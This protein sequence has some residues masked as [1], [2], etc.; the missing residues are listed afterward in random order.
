MDK[1]I[2]DHFKKFD[3]IL[4][5]AFQ[6]IKIL[7]EFEVRT[8]NDYFRSLCGEIIGQQLSGKAADTI[9]GRFEKLFSRKKITPEK[10]LKIPDEKLRGAGMAWS[11]V[12][13]IK[14]LAKK[15]T[16]GTLNL[17][18]LKD[19]EDH[20]VVEEITQVKGIGPWTAE[21]F[22]MFTLQRED[23]FSHGDLGLRK[24]IKKLYKFKKE[25]SK[26]QIEKIAQKW[27]PY[28]TYACRILW[29]SLEL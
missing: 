18:K 15:V 25:P 21:M 9:Y 22:L 23:V 4:Y 27:M 28:R 1:K 13:F 12:R 24:A 2:L 19:L 26:K 8:P 7:E 3:P 14:D 20:L 5:T 29:K 11:K 17:E 6:Q 16:D 10:V